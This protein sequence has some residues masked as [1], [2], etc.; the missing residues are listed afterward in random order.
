M[1]IHSRTPNVGGAA[2]FNRIAAMAPRF[3]EV[4]NPLDE[5]ISWSRHL[6]AH[7][8][9]GAV[10]E[11]VASWVNESQSS[12]LAAAEVA[13][14]S[15]RELRAWT[16]LCELVLSLPPPSSFALYMLAAAIAVLMLRC[17]AVRMRAAAILDAYGQTRSFCRVKHD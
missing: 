7:E 17:V 9:L 12:T 4:V 8:A 1:D 6:G 5:A 11:S 13:G 10:R 3:V 15:L 2:L 16:L 14:N